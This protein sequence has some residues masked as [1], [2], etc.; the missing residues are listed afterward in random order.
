MCWSPA[1]LLLFV[2][3]NS[4]CCSQCQLTAQ[5]ILVQ[6]CM[7]STTANSSTAGLSGLTSEREC[8]SL[9]FSICG[10][11]G[12]P[13]SP[14]KIWYAPGLAQAHPH[15]AM[16]QLPSFYSTTMYIKHLT[17]AI[18]LHLKTLRTHTQL[19]DAHLSH[20]CTSLPP[21]SLTNL[22]AGDGAKLS[23]RLPQLG[24]ACLVLLTH[25]R[26][27]WHLLSM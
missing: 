16:H 14:A 10:V 4:L 24:L 23:R 2:C 3:M 26:S 13:Q 20:T 9:W 12:L 15:N 6:L 11:T 7:D 19:L 25:C 1:S 27:C 22:G 8:I 17:T 5:S 21:T 18:W